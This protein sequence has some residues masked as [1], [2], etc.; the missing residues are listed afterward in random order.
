MM[1]R[2][3]RLEAK[4]VATTDLESVHQS[5]SLSSGSELL[6]PLATTHY[7]TKIALRIHTNC[8]SLTD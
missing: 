6:R 7:H 2:L 5:V 1:A 8:Y 3:E 4:V